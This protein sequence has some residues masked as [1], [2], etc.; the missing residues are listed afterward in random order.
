MKIDL[1][2]TRMAEFWKL[3][4]AEMEEVEEKTT[5][6]PNAKEGN[7]LLVQMITTCLRC[8]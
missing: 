2:F 7:I 8:A 4:W 5:E 3:A 6:Y 1:W